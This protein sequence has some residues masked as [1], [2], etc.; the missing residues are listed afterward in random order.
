MEVNTNHPQTVLQMG[1]LFLKIANMADNL[2][3]AKGITSNALNLGYEI[4][5][6]NRLKLGRNN[7]H[8]LESSEIKLDMASNQIDLLE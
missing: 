5:T 2:P 3:M 8:S 4:N 1:D 6:S 7:Y